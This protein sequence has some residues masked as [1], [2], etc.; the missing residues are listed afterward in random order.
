MG[1]EIENGVLIKYNEEQ[2]ITSITIPDSVTD[3]GEY[4]FYQCSGLTSVTIPESVVSIRESAFFGCSGI[5]NITV[6]ENN[7]SYSSENGILYNKDKTMLITCPAGK[8]GSI[9]IPDS[10]KNIGWRAFLG[11]T[12]L[13]SI[14]I[15]D[16]VKSIGWNA[17]IFCAGLKSKYADYKA[18][19]MVGNDIWC[20]DYIFKP[21]E[22]AEEI[23]EIGLCKKG[24]HFCTNLF[25]IF[26]Y[27]CGE[28]DKVIAIYECEI[29]DKV[30]HEKDSS[31]CVTNKIKPVKRLYQKDVIRILSGGELSEK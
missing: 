31:K 5:T 14:K 8:T 9:K 22:W 1:F 25:E 19:N 16:S 26:N 11:C 27:Y 6:N 17:F 21:N 7:K 4:S 2:E 28:I 24:Y 3:I 15:P 12:G 10:V 18:F 29:G 20:L 30:I 13:T 23:T